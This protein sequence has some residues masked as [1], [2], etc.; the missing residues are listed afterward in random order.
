MK[1]KIYK[2]INKLYNLYLKIKDI[3]LKKKSIEEICQKLIEDIPEEK[4]YLEESIRFNKG[5][6]GHVY[7]ADDFTEHLITMLKENKDT[8]KI[9]RYCNFIEYMWREGDSSVVNI[10]DVTIAENLSDFSIVWTRFG[11]YISNEFIE[12]INNDLLPHNVIIK[13]KPRLEKN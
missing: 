13:H 12:Y 2:C 5:I 11:K 8:K 10:F 7:F 4:E 3:I 6:L 1:Y 9:K